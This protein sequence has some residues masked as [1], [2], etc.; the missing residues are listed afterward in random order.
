MLTGATLGGTEAAFS[1][2]YVVRGDGVYQ[3]DSLLL[4]VYFGPGVDGAQHVNSITATKIDASA[5]PA[6]QAQRICTRF[7]P[8]DAV[9]QSDKRDSQGNLVQIFTSNRLAQ[10]FPASIF[11]PQQAGLFSIDYL[12][13]PGDSGVFECNIHLGGRA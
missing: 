9:H 4:N 12:R 7:T 10:T 6:D 5:W 8:P 13:L 11:Y 3:Q 2:Q 1:A